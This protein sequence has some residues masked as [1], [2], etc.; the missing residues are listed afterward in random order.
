MGIPVA[1]MAISEII[2]RKNKQQSPEFE[3]YQ[4]ILEVKEAAPVEDP[5]SGNKRGLKV[6][7]IGI[8][9]TGVM[10]LTLAF[11]AK[12]GQLLVAGMGTLVFLL[13][14]FLIVKARKTITPN[15]VQSN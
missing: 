10:L 15:E 4:K 13:G 12:N 7:G 5:S 6:I 2:L 1:L 11:L 8:A 3:A 14:G 9:L